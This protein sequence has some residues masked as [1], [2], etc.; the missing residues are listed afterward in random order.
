MVKL[1]LYVAAISNGVA[2]DS[3]CDFL[4]SQSYKITM[5]DLVPRFKAEHF[6]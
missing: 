5:C 3:F 4:K 2:N 6:L 1:D